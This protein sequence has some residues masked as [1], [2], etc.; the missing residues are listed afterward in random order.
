MACTH[1]NGTAVKYLDMDVMGRVAVILVCVMPLGGCASSSVATT[2]TISEN[3]TGNWQIQSG[4]AITAS[5][6]GGVFLTGAL[7]ANGAQVAGTINVTAPCIGAGA[8]SFAGAVSASGILT[9]DATPLPD[10]DVQLTLPA[11]SASPLATGTISSAGVVCATAFSGAAVGE[12]IANLSGTFAGPVTTAAGSGNVSMAL[13]QASMANANGQFPLTGSLTFTGTGCTETLAVTGTISGVG[14]TVA[15]ATEPVAGQNYVS[16]TGATNAAA[17]QIAA[18][19]ILFE[20]SPCSSSAS[21]SSTYAGT[22]VL[23]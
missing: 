17:S 3:L 22:L 23:Q 4:T 19:G 6:T 18:S 1:L 11:S 21:S 13:T 14:L 7:T 5:S 8:Q 2:T 9:L 15:S 10:V 16:L 20:P 12:Q